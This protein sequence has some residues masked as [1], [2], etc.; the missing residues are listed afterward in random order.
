MFIMLAYTRI[1]IQYSLPPSIPH[2]VSNSVHNDLLEILGLF[3]AFEDTWESVLGRSCVG[4]HEGEDNPSG[5]VNAN[6]LITSDDIPPSHSPGAGNPR[7]SIEYFLEPTAAEHEKNRR[8]VRCLPRMALHI[9]GV[10][11]EW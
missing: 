10:Y 7:T 2:G 4:E 1:M 8:D 3:T 6:G 9:H 5:N 11:I